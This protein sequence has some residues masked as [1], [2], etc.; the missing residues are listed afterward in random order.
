MSPSYDLEPEMYTRG[1]DRSGTARRLEK[2]YGF[3]VINFANPD[4][5]RDTGSIPAV[6]TAVETTDTLPRPGRRGDRRTPAASAS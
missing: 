4:I 1:A 2:G 5:V 3:A 6:I